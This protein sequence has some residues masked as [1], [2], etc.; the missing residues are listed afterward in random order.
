MYTC[1]HKWVG[2]GQRE[3]SRDCGGSTIC[4]NILNNIR[5]SNGS[6]LGIKYLSYSVSTKVQLLRRIKVDTLRFQ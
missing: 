2:W 6:S 4:S 5:R 3:V 1:L